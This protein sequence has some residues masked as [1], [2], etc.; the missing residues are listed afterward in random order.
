MSVD[1]H[2]HSNKS[3]GSLSPTMLVELASQKGLSAIALTDHDTTDGLDEAIDAGKT[4]GVNVI[5]G[6]ELSCEYQGKDVHI[7]GLDIDHNNECFK[8]TLREFVDS[9]VLRNQKMCQKLTEYG[10]PVDY[11][12]LINAYGE[13]VIT[14]AHYARFMLDKGYIKSL[15][16]AFERYIGDNSPCYIPREKVTPAQ[17]VELILSAGGIPVLAH[18]LLYKMGKDR[19]N[20]LVLELKDYGLKALEAIY[21]TYTLSDTREMYAL[22]RKHN[23]LISGGSD[24]HGAA[25]PGLEL[26]T[27]YGKLYIDD[28]ILD[29]LL[30]SKNKL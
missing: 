7:V 17:G 22:A 20:N 26:G 4:Y 11:E 28:E 24:F 9:R 6:V 1:L 29:N 14:R 16:E 30:A 15:P 21:C 13:S 19:L 2:T 18:P 3:D 12:E 5:A 27:G 10:L 25:K 23:L 8:S